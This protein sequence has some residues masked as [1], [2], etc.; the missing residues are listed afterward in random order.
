MSD[1][2]S[3]ISDTANRL[4]ADHVT[5]A[6]LGAAEEGSTD[7]SLWQLISETGLPKILL[8]MR[9]GGA[10]GTWADAAVVVKAAGRYAV[11]EPVCEAIAAHWLIDRIGFELPGDAM[12]LWAPATA[13]ADDIVIARG[14]WASRASHLLAWTEDTPGTLYLFDMAKAQVRPGANIAGEPRGNVS[15]PRTSALAQC[16][17]PDALQGITPR[18]LGALLRAG[19]IAGALDSA[20]ALTVDYS[21]ERVQFGRPIGKFQAIQQQLA[22]MAG[23]V[24][25][26]GR[27]ADA[28]FEA[29][30]RPDGKALF[31]IA[32]AKTRAGE[33]VEIATSV[34]HQVHGA[35]GITYEYHL[36][37][38]TRRLWSWRAEFGS[39]SYWAAEIGKIVT[40]Q[41][42][43]ALWP[44]ITAQQEL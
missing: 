1:M 3:L 38:L 15:L 22:L 42:A 4:F 44:N 28:A 6:Y 34:A 18:A 23:H 27:A 5:P 10:N 21:K 25:A 9:A 14:P 43:D 26:A 35:I 41:G 19:Q 8:R 30:D 2:R 33:A 11:P 32:V 29:M 36:Q 39:D 13:V 31:D 24:A 16:A 40:A 17:A 7:A 37:F 20:L 12:P